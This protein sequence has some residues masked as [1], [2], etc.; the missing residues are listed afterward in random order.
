MRQDHGDNE[1]KPLQLLGDNEDCTVPLCNLI[2]TG[3][4]VKYLHNGNIIY[5]SDGNL[6]VRNLARFLQ[7]SVT[8][9]YAAEGQT[10]RRAKDANSNLQP[11]MYDTIFSVYEQD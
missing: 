7:N 4:A 9:N 11:T 1:V 8:R 5:N 2:L 10:R 3:R 6:I